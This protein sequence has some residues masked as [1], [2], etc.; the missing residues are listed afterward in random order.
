MITKFRYLI[1]TKDTIVAEYYTLEQIEQGI[2]FAHMAMPRRILSRDLYI[3]TLGED[4]AELYVND[5]LSR[6]SIC[7]G[8]KEYHNFALIDDRF[9]HYNCEGI[10]GNPNKYKV[11]GNITQHP[12]L[13][14]GQ[15]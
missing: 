1:A 15:A 14:E 8:I 6:E 5:I 7:S 12:E 4:G 3:G 9:F 10:L 13:L 2:N 11:L